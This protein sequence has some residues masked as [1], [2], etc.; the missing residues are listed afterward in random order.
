MI[1][2]S[3]IDVVICRSDNG[4]LIEGTNPV[5]MEYKLKAKQ[6]FGKVDANFQMTPRMA[7]SQSETK[8]RAV[9]QTAIIDTKKALS[10]FGYT[11]E[12]VADILVKYLYG[13]NNSKHKDLLWSCYGEILFNNLSR[14]KKKKTKDIKCIDCGQW[15]EVNINN[16]KSYRCNYCQQEHIKL[17]DR[18]RKQNNNSVQPLNF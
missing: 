2:F 1:I 3:N 14:H 15:F 10:Q 6:F 17:Y 9:F 13:I 11:D 8:Q 18:K 5:I 7:L 12:E 4:R 16:T